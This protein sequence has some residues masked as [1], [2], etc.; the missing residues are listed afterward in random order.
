MFC[1][2]SIYLCQRLV[3]LSVYSYS[4][5]ANCNHDV[6]EHSNPWSFIE[7]STAFIHCFRHVFQKVPSTT[8]KLHRLVYYH[9]YELFV[10]N[11][12]YYVRVR[13]S[14]IFWTGHHI[15]PFIIDS[16]SSSS[17]LRVNNNQ[18]IMLPLVH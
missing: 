1:L 6:I 12:S 16:W 14:N 17:S 2:H 13:D 18:S 4:C 15:T 11:S 3:L 9:N 5:R 8:W 7:L 10:D